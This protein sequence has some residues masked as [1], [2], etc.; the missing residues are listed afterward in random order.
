MTRV[1][2]TTATHDKPDEYVA[3]ALKA[4]AKAK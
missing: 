2:P 1:N 3:A 4:G